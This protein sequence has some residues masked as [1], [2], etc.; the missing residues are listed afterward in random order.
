MDKFEFIIVLL[1]IL[2]ASG[3]IAQ[4]PA[5]VEVATVIEAPLQQ[6]LNLSGSLRA[7]QHSALSAQVDGYVTAV[8]VQAGDRVQ[9]GQ[10]VIALDDTLPKLELERLQSALREAESLL[11]RSQFS[12]LLQLPHA[13][14]ELTDLPIRLQSQRSHHVA[15]VDQTR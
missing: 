9:P 14:Q 11:A 5:R 8:P 6:S 3:S 4:E 12:S 10:V 2:I 13:L 15:A 7:P 1:S